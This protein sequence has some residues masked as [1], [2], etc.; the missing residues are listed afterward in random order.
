MSLPAFFYDAGMGNLYEYFS[1]AD[2][3]TA[4]AVH[5]LIG[6]PTA[7]SAFDTLFT[8]GIEPAVQISTLEGLLTGRSLDE[9][10][11]DPRW[12]KA[13]VPDTGAGHGVLTLNDAVARAL[14]T[15]DRARLAEVAVP[16]SQTEEFRGQADPDHLTEFLVE[17]SALARRAADRG[18]RLY[19]WWSL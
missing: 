3:Q 4:A 6:G 12:S 5:G 7:D 8:K 10:F 16:W 11:A 13:V 17:L 14:A 15:A 1:A 9:I 2:D 19:C 18:H